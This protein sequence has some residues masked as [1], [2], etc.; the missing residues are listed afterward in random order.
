MLKVKIKCVT[1]LDLQAIWHTGSEK[2][3]TVA[4]KAN[5]A[6]HTSNSGG[7]ITFTIKDF[8]SAYKF[9]SSWNDGGQ[10]LIPNFDPNII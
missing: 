10:F 6:A 2:Y 9:Y 7:F 8:L 5:V 4:D 3:I 1:T